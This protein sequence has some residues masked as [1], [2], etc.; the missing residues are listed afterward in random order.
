MSQVF[1]QGAVCTSI[2]VHHDELPSPELETSEP[3]IKMNSLFI[4][5][6]LHGTLE[7]QLIRLDIQNPAKKHIFVPSLRQCTQRFSQVSEAREQHS[8]HWTGKKELKSCLLADESVLY[9][10]S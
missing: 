4:R 10:K 2:H 6:L 9:R 1:M 8:M 3:G 7:N 5:S